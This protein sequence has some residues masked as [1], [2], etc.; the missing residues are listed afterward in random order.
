MLPPSRRKS[1]F[2]RIVS[3]LVFIQVTQCFCPRPFRLPINYQ[4]TT[5]TNLKVKEN[6]AN[7]QCEI[8]IRDSLYGELND[9]VEVIMKSFYPDSKP[10]W[11][12][13]YRLAELN[14]LQQGFPYADREMHRMLVAVAKEEECETVVGFVDCD[15]RKPN[16]PTSFNFNPRPYISDLCVSPAFR[17]RGIAN[18]LVKYCEEY[19][20]SRGKAEIYIR[21][22]RTNLAAI[23]MYAAL[24]YNEI[25]N[26]LD[27]SK[28]IVILHKILAN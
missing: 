17:R 23:S 3:L 4:R 18:Q 10:P 25:E 1:I 20:Q 22:E 6:A 27:D 26:D 15:L 7:T 24:G 5:H 13:M 12:H 28:K 19:C 11:N 16:R 2:A 8:K 14:R 21:V 9:A